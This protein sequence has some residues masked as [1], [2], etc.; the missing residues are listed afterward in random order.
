[1]SYDLSAVLP[2]VVIVALLAFVGGIASVNVLGQSV[3]RHHRARVSRRTTA[4]SCWPTDPE[5]P[6]RSEPHAPRS[7]SSGRVGAC[8][9]ATSVRCAGPTSTS[10]DT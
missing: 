1:M 10:W 3:V 6:S 5:H 2:F 8:A 7:A 9:I 4:T